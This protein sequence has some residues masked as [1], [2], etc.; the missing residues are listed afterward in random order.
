ML[1][2][3]IYHKMIEWKNNSNGSTALLIDGA[4][5][6]GKS[7]IVKEFAT[8][9]YKSYITIDFGIASQDVLDL[10]LYDSSNLDLFFAKLS[11]YYSVPLYKRESLIIFDEVQQFPR[12]RQ[13]IKYL[14]ADSRFDYIE[15]GSLIRLKK[16]V[17]DIIIPS[18]EEHIEM[19]PLD[20]EEFL[21]AM[22][23]ET[24]APLMKMCFDS[25]KPLGQSLHRK[26]MNDFRQYV[27]VGGM[28]QSVNAYLDSKNF[29]ACDVA[30]RRIL[31]LY[32][33]DV[34][35]F[36]KGYENKV[37]ALFDA[38]PGQLSKKEK[39][40][41]LSSISKDARFRTYEDS[42]IW[43]HEAMIVNNCFNATDPSIGLALSYENTKQKCYM[44]DTGLL[45]T[46]TFMDTAFTENE[47]YKAILF[48]KLN[49]NEGMIME[50]VVAQMLRSN[51]HKLYFYSR[52]DNINRENH[53]EIDFLISEN[54]K[55]SPIEVKSSNYTTHSSL[56]KFKKKF[57][58]KIENS[59]I[60]YSKDVMI[61]DGIIHLP[62]YMALF[63]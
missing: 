48:D 39:K 31:K 33:D 51:G 26:I 61:K 41:T 12:A 19:F 35:K 14:V 32:R 7:Y 5:R 57:S 10:F 25:K 1:K 23:D 16:N 6:V 4:R 3:K 58:S 40:Y 63:L 54:K 37:F 13:L 24:T 20:F 60:L 30:K 2:R 45:V 36:A 11:A 56:D 42:F 46:H 47:L 62:F 52:C 15:T 21:W 44:A 17:Q 9:E 28:A 27:L 50:N 53:M 8:N 59:Y 43:L 55:I 34:S 49:V 22:G 18:E 29:E 38:I